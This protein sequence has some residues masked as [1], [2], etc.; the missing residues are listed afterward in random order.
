MNIQGGHNTHESIGIRMLCLGIRAGYARPYRGTAIGP[1]I[2][3]L[4][5]NAGSC[6][7]FLDAFNVSPST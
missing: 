3:R 1:L 4:M 2:Y 7:Y 5:L 6:G